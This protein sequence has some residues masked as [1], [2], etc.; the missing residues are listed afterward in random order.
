M[1]NKIRK[2]IDGAANDLLGQVVR[3]LTF[4]RLVDAH[5]QGFSL[6]NAAV[7]V[8]VAKVAMHADPSITELAALMASLLAYQG[9]RMSRAKV[10]VTA[11]RINQIEKA[12]GIANEAYSG[13][14]ALSDKVTHMDNR[15]K[16]REANGGR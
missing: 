5:D 1:I 11:E 12:V 7:I 14:R 16:T 2:A 4:L 10:Q 15:I 13:L 8:C 9:K 6:T 3:L